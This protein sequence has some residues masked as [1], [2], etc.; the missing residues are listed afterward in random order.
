MENKEKEIKKGLIVVD[1]INGFINEGALADKGIDRITPEIYRLVC[2]YLN[3]GDKIIACKDVHTKESPELHN[4][5][6]HCIKGTSEAELVPALHFLEEM[7]GTRNVDVIEKNSTSLF[8][9]PEFINKVRDLDEVA[10]T[11]CCTD[12]CVMNL[13]IPLKN[14]FNQ[15]NKNAKVVVPE[16]AVETYNIPNVHD[17]DEWNR[18]AFKFMRQAGVEVVKTLEVGKRKNQN[19]VSPAA[20]KR[21][22]EIGLDWLEAGRK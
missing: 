12:I 6:A 9:V 8:V 10:I 1:M 15:I 2:G 18:D 16:N 21:E 4:F 20:R 22:I 19:A 3:N 11:G 5:P 7:K 17:R 14:Y 13:A